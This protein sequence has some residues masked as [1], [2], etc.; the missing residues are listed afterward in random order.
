MRDAPPLH[1][2]VPVWGERYVGVFLD[3]CL[4]AQ[5]SADNIPALGGAGVNRYV[6]Y[7]T[8]ADHH[9]LVAAPAYLALQRMISV[10][11][12][13]IDS[14]LT[15]SGDAP[16]MEKYQVKSECYRRALICAATA[17]AAVIAL[18][19]DIL[20][21]NGFVRSVIDLLARGKRV[22]EVP[23]PRGLLDPIGRALISRFRGADGVSIS[24]EPT[25]LSA[26]WLA[27]MHPQLE[28]HHVEGPAG[29]VFHPS[30]L[31]W[32]V[33]EQGVIIRGFHLYP[34][35]TEPR[36]SA[37]RIG[38]SIDDDL[39][40]NLRLSPDDSFLAQDSRA[41]F[42]CEMSPPEHYVGQ[43]A[44]RGD[45]RRYVEFYLSYAKDNIKNLEKEIII[46]GTTHLGPEWAVRRKQSALFIKR[47]L[48]SYN[49]E[50]RRRVQ[51]AAFR[52]MCH[53]LL[54]PVISRLRR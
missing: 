23:G 28:M 37:I 13:Y 47:L 12:E 4:P 21:A 26:L 51:R 10:S 29:G 38:S 46:S 9:R 42:C 22:I 35:V 3:Y 31:Y 39:V 52:S 18:N 45:L 32:L 30:H 2:V 25:E 41:M 33:G 17:G 48:R 8:H 5:L 27:N 49:N 7:T 19:A 1:F 24:I 20:L 43:M 44:E 14:M 6:I 50:R 40:A 54:G 15:T 34:I 53:R 11:I 36:D 16:A